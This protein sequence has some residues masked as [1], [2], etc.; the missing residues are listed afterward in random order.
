MA[1]IRVKSA[2]LHSMD[3]SDNQF[4]AVKCLFTDSDGLDHTLYS[5]GILCGDIM[6][7][8]TVIFDYARN[9][10]MFVPKGE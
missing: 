6:N 9:R 7:R 5:S 4:T 10:V 8:C 3:L 1:G 2:L